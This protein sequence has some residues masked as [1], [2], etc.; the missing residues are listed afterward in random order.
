MNPET[1]AQI[2]D[3]LGGVTQAVATLEPKLR[4]SLRELCNRIADIQE[5]QGHNDTLAAT[6][7]LAMEFMQQPHAVADMCRWCL[8]MTGTLLQVVEISENSDDE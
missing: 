7:F 1:E 8:L 6:S 5:R 4:E 3:L 2:A